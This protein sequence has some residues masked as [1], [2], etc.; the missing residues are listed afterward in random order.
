[1]AVLTQRD[2]VLLNA[3]PTVR[4]GDKMRAWGGVMVAA[5]DTD[6]PVTLPDRI[7]NRFWYAACLCLLVHIPPPFERFQPVFLSR[8]LRFAVV[9][10]KVDQP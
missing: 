4:A 9:N 1:M 7:F 2:Y 5:H 3:E 10:D 6:V 8:S